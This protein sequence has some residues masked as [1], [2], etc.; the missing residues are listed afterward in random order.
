MPEDPATK[1]VFLAV[2]TTSSPFYFPADRE[3]PT[4]ANAPVKEPK[5]VGVAF[6]LF[7]KDMTACFG[8]LERIVSSFYG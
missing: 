2:A 1:S 5:Y 8:R 3:A 7:A 4:K 6:A